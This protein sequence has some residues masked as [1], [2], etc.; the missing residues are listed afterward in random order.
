[1][2]ALRKALARL[3]QPNALTNRNPGNFTDADILA[4]ADRAIAVEREKE[5]ARRARVQEFAYLCFENDDLPTPMVLEAYTDE[6]CG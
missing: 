6:V 5:A 4:I 2:T 3:K 1:M